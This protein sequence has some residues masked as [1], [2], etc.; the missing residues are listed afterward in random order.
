MN[1]NGKFS[2][3]LIPTSDKTILAIDKQLSKL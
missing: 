2:F 1:F 3:E